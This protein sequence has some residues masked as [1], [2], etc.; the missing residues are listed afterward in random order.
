MNPDVVLYD[1]YN[2][3]GYSAISSQNFEPRFDA[4]DAQ[5]ADDF[6]VPVGQ[7]WIVDQVDVAG[8]YVGG[9]SDS[10]NVFFYT[11]TNALPGAPVF[12]QTNIIPSAGL[13]S[14]NFTLILSP[15]ATLTS[16]TYWVSVQANQDQ[17]SQGQWFWR[18][19]AVLSNNGAA[20]RNPGSG[21]GRPSCTT[22]WGRRTFSCGLSY[23]SPDQ[24]FRIGGLGLS[25]PTATVTG[26]PP[27]STRT[28]TSTSTGTRPSSPTS[29]NTATPG[30]PTRTGTRYVPPPVATI[31]V[32]TVTRST[33][34][35]A[36]ST[37]APSCGLYARVVPSENLG[38]FGNAF[39]DVDMISAS[40]G[41]SVG[42][43][44]DGEIVHTLTMR[45]DGTSWYHV[46]S[47]DPLGT[48]NA[49]LTEV[50]AISP[51]DAW[52]VGYYFANNG[53]A[54]PMSL[55][56]NGTQWNLVAVN[57][58]GGLGDTYLFGIDAVSPQDVWAVGRY[59]T[60]GE[61]RAFIVRWNG[62]QWSQ[63][64]LPNLGSNSGLFG[65]TAISA[66]DVWAAIILPT[67][68]GS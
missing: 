29:T 14:G 57:V 19:R 20:W 43:Y 67:L 51:D 9:P 13:E 53:P 5:A 21:F 25:T 41:W 38:F 45:W 55:H 52:A 11:S 40:D 28:P 60:A 48:T 15:P 68:Q 2:S 12:T 37:P 42:Y 26:T 10:V 58:A 18:N 56:W 63:I 61:L 24:V 49:V 34:P 30:P 23:E 54:R 50:K 46:P 62:T 44:N 66:T 33:T 65:I 17:E 39:Q 16:G 31:P 3:H 1:Q 27:T 59:R 6:I 8:A 47:P 4:Y 7:I 36:T 64:T 22:N 35:I 32:S